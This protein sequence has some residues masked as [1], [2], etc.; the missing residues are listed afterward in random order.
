[1][2]VSQRDSGA[3]HAG[4]GAN[5]MK[6]VRTYCR[7]RLRSGFQFGPVG[8]LHA[9]VG[10]LLALVAA[11]GGGGAAPESSNG[12]T[13]A[14][15]PQGGSVEPAV[16]AIP[17]GAA[18]IEA[19]AGGAADAA[20]GPDSGPSAAV[21]V[22]AAPAPAPVMPAVLNIRRPGPLFAPNGYPW[23]PA[24]GYLHGYEIL[25]GGGRSSITLDNGA[26]DRNMWVK[27]FAHDATGAMPV[28]QIFLPAHGRF[29][30]AGVSV[31]TYDVRY[32]NLWDS[33]LVGTEPFTLTETEA[34]G[35]IHYRHLTITLYKVPDGNMRTHALGRDQF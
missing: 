22:A 23:P 15:E 17:A 26:N 2:L 16:A 1:M 29:T 10:G 30:M 35:R 9:V 11:C 8:P 24:G 14:L 20:A 13:A 32:M 31:G 33:S 12:M 6:S 27:L 25:H 4:R 18:T 34:A 28:R 19:D 5:E 21:T 7:N 3:G